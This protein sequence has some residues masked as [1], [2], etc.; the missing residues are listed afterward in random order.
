MSKEISKELRIVS[1]RNGVEISVEKDRI[2]TLLPEIEK[3]RF[4]EINGEIVSTKDIVGIFTPQAIE[5]TI[6]RK[7]GQWQCK[8]NYWH[9]R[10]EQ[11]AHG[12]LEKYNK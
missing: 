9:E 7:N 2:E 3:R 12:E 10:G 4:F 8:Y 6:R 5:D 1:L 11:C